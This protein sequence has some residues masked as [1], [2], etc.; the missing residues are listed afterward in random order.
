MFKA[1][2]DRAVAAAEPTCYTSIVLYLLL[3]KLATIAS[4]EG[5]ENNCTVRSIL[6][7]YNC[8][9]AVILVCVKY[10]NRFAE[11]AVAL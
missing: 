4:T 3:H 5:Q 1:F 6:S 10:S 7:S 11:V 2:P 8:F 9:N